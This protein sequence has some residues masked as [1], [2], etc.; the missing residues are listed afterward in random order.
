[1]K[2]LKSLVASFLLI[3]ISTAFATKSH[4]Q[5]VDNYLFN[6][7]VT[8]GGHTAQEEAD[9]ADPSLW[10]TGTPSGVTGSKFEGAKFTYNASSISKADLVTALGNYYKTQTT[11]PV[12]TS[13]FPITVTVSGVNITV[14]VEIFIKI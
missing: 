10:S 5:T 1:M 14:T 12:T 13:T 2:I 6:G 7:N 11:L 8:N 4:A 3:A 9:F